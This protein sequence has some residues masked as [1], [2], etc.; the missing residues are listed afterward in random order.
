MPGHQA[1]PFAQL[2]AAPEVVPV[3]DGAQQRGGGGLGALTVHG[4]DVQ[5][6]LS[7]L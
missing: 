5:V 2:T 6:V 7:R 4:A 1:E 3:A